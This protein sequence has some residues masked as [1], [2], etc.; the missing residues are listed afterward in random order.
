MSLSLEDQARLAGSQ[1]DFRNRVEAA[2]M[3]AAIAAFAA[4]PISGTGQAQ[5]IGLANAIVRQPGYALDTFAWVVVSRPSLNTA[6][7]ITDANI[8]QIVTQ[9]FDVIAAQLMPGGP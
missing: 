2:S 4:P 5:R 8:R 6:D 1:S 9:T 7:D 3:G